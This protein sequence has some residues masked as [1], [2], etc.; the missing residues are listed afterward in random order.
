MN[1]ESFALGQWPQLQ[2]IRSTS[3]A[4]AGECFR[5]HWMRK[6]YRN[7]EQCTYSNNSQLVGR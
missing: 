2:P 4:P 1:E 5:L 7:G 6:W 3:T